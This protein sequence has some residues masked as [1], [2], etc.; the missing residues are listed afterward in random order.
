MDWSSLGDNLRRDTPG[1]GFNQNQRDYSKMGQNRIQGVSIEE[2]KRPT[3]PV[4]W[5]I[6]HQWQATETFFGETAPPNKT[7]NGT[8]IYSCISTTTIH[9]AT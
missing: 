3:V 4:E 2:L 1:I 5:Q 8:F 9:Q 6:S 7:Y